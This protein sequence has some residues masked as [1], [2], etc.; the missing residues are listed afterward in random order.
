MNRDDGLIN[1]GAHGWMAIL[2]DGMVV[3]AGGDEC[4]GR[5]QRARIEESVKCDC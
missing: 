3:G 2:I 5:V 4:F 1:P